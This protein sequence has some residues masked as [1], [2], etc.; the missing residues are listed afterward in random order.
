MKLRS[1]SKKKVYYYK[2]C[3]NNSLIDV[4]INSQVYERYLIVRCPQKNYMF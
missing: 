3:F 1:K 4:L 2:K